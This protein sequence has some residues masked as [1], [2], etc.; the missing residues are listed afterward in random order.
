MLRSA[1]LAA[2]GILVVASG[3][4][5]HGGSTIDRDPCVQKTGNW[6]VHFTVYEPELD[7]A[8]EYCRD[9]PKAGPMIVVFDLVDLELRKLPMDLQ[10]VKL[11]DG[12][13]EPVHHV[14]AVAYPNGVLNTELTVAEPGRY[15]AI[16]TP[17]GRPPVVFP[18]R[19]EMQ[20]PVWIWLL[21]LVAIAPVL[22]Y[23]SQRRTPPP[24]SAE[25]ARKNLALVK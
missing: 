18:M 7:P 22:Y 19:I 11:A 25:D 20:M 8:G 16:L 1:S 5:A 13:Q 10:I 24:A 3:A 6:L 4:F 23:W 15:A 2:L 9:V 12:G 17:E 14:P 21:P